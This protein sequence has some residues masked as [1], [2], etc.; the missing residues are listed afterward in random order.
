MSKYPQLTEMGI[1]HPE[2]IRSYMVNSISRID[3]LRIIYKR[4]EGSLL[5]CSRSYEFPR[6]QKTIT[7]SKG[8]PETVLETAP[9][10]RAAVAELKAL[11]ELRENE[12]LLAA[13][14]LEELESLEYE[15]AYR[16]Q[17]MKDLLKSV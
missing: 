15:L 3:V 2:E 13:S 4:K 11:M 16:I 9:A 1:L 7:N 6:V 12:P 14:M 5:P 17:N 10:L 8:E